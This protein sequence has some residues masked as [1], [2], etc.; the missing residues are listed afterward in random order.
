MAPDGSPPGMCGAQLKPTARRVGDR[1]LR[2]AEVVG[3]GVAPMR[4]VEGL[5]FN[6]LLARDTAFSGRGADVAPPHAVLHPLTVPSDCHR[7]R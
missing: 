5:R 4:L 2:L 7:Q 1:A 3:V 6:S